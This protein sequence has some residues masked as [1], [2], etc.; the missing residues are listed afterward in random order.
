M[1]GHGKTDDLMDREEMV[2][3]FKEATSHTIPLSTEYITG[4][5]ERV[6]PEIPMVI[7]HGGIDY[8]LQTM[9]LESGD[10]GELFLTY[11]KVE[12]NG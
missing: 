11:R 9:S 5:V 4:T 10:D 8:K 2:R 3:Q 6:I 7:T 1:G 12:D